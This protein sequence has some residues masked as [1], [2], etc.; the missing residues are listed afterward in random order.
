M[1]GELTPVFHRPPERTTGTGTKCRRHSRHPS[2]D[3]LRLSL[4]HRRK[5]TW[6]KQTLTFLTVLAYYVEQGLWNCV[7][8]VCLLWPLFVSRITQAVTYGLIKYWCQG[9]SLSLAS[10]KSRQVLPFWYRLTRIVPDKG[11]LNG[12]ARV[13]VTYGVYSLCL[14]LP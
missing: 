13:C 9:H 4:H 5:H 10:V 11:Q 7:V 8:S 3:V 2:T 1:P 12:C 14:Q 6:H